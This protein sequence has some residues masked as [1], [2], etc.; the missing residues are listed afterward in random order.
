MRLLSVGA[1]GAQ[2]ISGGAAPVKLHR[3]GVGSCLDS[4]PP[5]LKY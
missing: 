5:E 3:Q 1:V 2:G 4:R